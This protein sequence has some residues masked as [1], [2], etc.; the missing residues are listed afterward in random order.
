MNRIVMLKR[1][2]VRGAGDGV[3]MFIVVGWDCL[4]FCPPVCVEEGGR[5]EEV[6]VAGDVW[7]VLVQ[8]S[9][10]VII[11]AEGLEAWREKW[12]S[13]GRVGRAKNGREGPPLNSLRLFL[14]TGY[15]IW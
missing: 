1:C 14:L 8:I 10:H 5:E 4:G 7:E 12:P 9:S 15:N 3:L 13:E 11:V 6:T 2:L